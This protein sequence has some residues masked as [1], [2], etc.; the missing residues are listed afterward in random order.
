MKLRPV[1][2]A[3]EGVFL[4]GMAHF[5]KYM[6]ETISQ[7][8]AAASR[9]ATILSKDTITA[10]G[11]VC[12]VNGR[13]CIGCG[14]CFK[15]CQFGAIEIQDTLEG[16][17][18]HVTTTVCRGCGVC[19]SVCPTSAISLNHFTDSQIFAEVEAA[20][21]VSAKESHF[22]PKI[23][24]FLCNWCGYA[25]SDMAGVSK[26]QYAP[27]VR[28]IRVMCSS[29]IH[30][31]FIASAFLNGIDGVL[32]CGCHLGDCHYINANYQTEKTIKSGKK[33]LEK[34]GINPG[35]LRQE[36][37]SASEGAKYAL[38]VNSFT[39]DLRKLG[40]LELDDEQKEKLL[41]LKLKKARGK[42]SKEEN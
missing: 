9:A 5:P 26:I 2:F 31:K 15:V 29:R 1:D 34:M 28:E 37:I 16:K 6:E 10:S 14:A 13:E 3:S 27:N 12:D 41:K 38:A 19:N 20:Y 23:V 17:K 22:E 32:V 25:G 36:Y 24:G 39:E 40:P 8:H 4:S 21:L 33:T 35:R 11:V 42:T 30:P 7:A 18:A